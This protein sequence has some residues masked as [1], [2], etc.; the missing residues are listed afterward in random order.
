MEEFTEHLE[1]TKVYAS[2]H[3][4][5]DSDS[6]RTTKVTSRKYRIYTYLQKSQITEY[7]LESKGPK[8]DVE[9][10]SLESG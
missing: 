8:R 7:A 9:Q 2:V 6:E 1:D 3:I 10:K 5:H 4:S